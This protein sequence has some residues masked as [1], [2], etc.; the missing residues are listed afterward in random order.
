MGSC[1]VF[2]KEQKPYNKIL[3]IPSASALNW[4]IF[5]HLI[6]TLITWGSGSHLRKDAIVDI[7][8]FDIAATRWRS[9]DTC[10]KT[11][12]QSWFNALGILEDY[13]TSYVP[14]VTS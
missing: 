5:G 13:H 12:A 2:T 11:H 9:A 3:E 10:I 1:V 14:I 4:F 6:E 8:W 7:R